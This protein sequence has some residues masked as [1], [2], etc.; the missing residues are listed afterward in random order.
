MSSEVVTR[1]NPFLGPRSF[2]RGETLYGR[3]REARDLLSLLIAERI[4]LLHSPSGAGKTSLVQAALVPLLEEREFSVLPV[5]RVNTEPPNVRSRQALVGSQPATNNGHGASDAE[6]QRIHDARPLNRYT[7]SVLLSLEEQLPPEQQT[8]LAELA[9][10]PLADYLARRIPADAD[11]VLIFDQFEEVLTLDPTDIAAK[12]AFFEQ[13]SLALRDRR[14]WAL[15]CMRE[16]YV[17]ALEPYLRQVPTQ[18]G[19]HFRLDL[20]GVSGATQAL[21]EPARR[22]GVGFDE[23]A[24]AQ[25][26][27]DLRVVNTQQ[28]D[29][30]IRQQLGPTVEPVQLQVVGYRLWQRLPDN[31]EAITT[32]DIAA[33]GDVNRALSDYYEAQVRAAAVATGVRE[34]ALREWFDHALITEQGLR[35]QVLQGGEQSGGLDNRA[36]RPLIDAYLVRAEPRRGATW[37]ELA[38][39]RLI[40]PVRASNGAWFAAN[41]STLQRQAELWDRQSR[42][43]G[44]LLRGET[45]REAEEWAATQ[46]AELTPVEQDF[47][48][49]CRDARRQSRRLRG[50]AIGA[51]VLSVLALCA[52]G[53][54]LWFFTRSEQQ[55]RI[56][57]SREL[58]ASALGSLSI[59]PERSVLLALQAAEATRSAGEPVVPEAL[60][61]LAQ[62]TDASRVRR[63]LTGHTAEVFDVATSPDG[64]LVATSGKDGTIRLWNAADG[65]A[66][67]TLNSPGGEV[68]SL[69]FSP[70]GTLLAAGGKDGLIV[71]AVASGRELRQ[72]KTI[73]EQHGLGPAALLGVAYSA[74][75]TLLA[76]AGEDGFATIWRAADGQQ[77]LRISANTGNGFDPVGLFQDGTPAPV[78]ALNAVAFSPDGTLLATGGE[79]TIVRIWDLEAALKA[80]AA[81]QAPP[82]TLLGGHADEIQD[83]AFSP[84]G[85]LLASA[86]L[87]FQAVVWDV[88]SGARQATLAG[89]AKPVYGVTF[90]PDGTL[91]ATASGDGSAKIWRL[92]GGP[93]LLTLAGHAGSVEAVAFV[94]GGAAL[95][96]ASDDT[97][98]RIWSLAMLPPDGATYVATSPDGALLASAGNVGARLWDAQSGTPRALAFIIPDSAHPDTSATSAAFSPDGKRLA[99]AGGDNSAKIWDVAALLSSNIPPAPLL[100]L[101]GHNQ[102]VG[103]VAYSPDGKHLATASDDR[104]ARVWDAQNGQQLLVLEG[105]AAEVN[106]LAYSSDGTR[107]ATAGQDNHTIVWDAQTGKQ[108]LDLDS[109]TPQNAVAFS[110]DGKWLTSVG[111]DGVAR[112]YDLANRNQLR[113]FQHT[114]AL[115]AV[116]FSPDGKWLATGGDDR[117]AQLWDAA[118]GK[119]LFTLSHPAEVYAL[120]F[121]PDGKRLFSA[122]ADGVLR[123]FPLEL[124]DLL[125]LG[126]ERATRALSSQ[127][128]QTYNIVPCPSQP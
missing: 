125:R 116:A 86:S 121:S 113:V 63:V 99:T 87:D 74:D 76:G 12:Q 88:A 71:W 82:R 40:E 110:P 50:L 25:L 55:R 115:R 114:K 1:A 53:A 39:D 28:P 120:T 11:G 68:D 23:A 57:I 112:L 15:F 33:L 94:L 58:I 127:E 51:S 48:Q 122:G 105:H 96:T 34:R 67:T 117:T 83:L 90:S 62:T 19:R 10:T 65:S 36:I 119:P 84:N 126:H 31:A 79:D 21:R 81:P 98:A 59:D 3:D 13:L 66:G 72:L 92:G 64:K 85:T 20:L 104:T 80:G 128:C 22:L 93:P 42:P 101:E 32:A 6:R 8:G 60:G 9:G 52:L 91:L 45:L 14:Y 77:L 97:T 107:L 89:H 70:D 44:L 109:K 29:G 37:F 7:L 16:D 49:L 111:K 100:V 24:V 30:S 26:I 43:A 118:S 17:A 46:A 108:L 27:D 35:G 69:A 54:A 4:V 41:L 5:I 61:A 102:V 95:A 75:G 18:L 106:G 47:L 2:Q 56:A 124:D 78:G 103:R 123:A 73:D 38:H